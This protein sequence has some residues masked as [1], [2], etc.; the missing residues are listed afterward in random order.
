M[1]VLAP[2]VEW[3]AE[4]AL[5]KMPIVKNWTDDKTEGGCPLL[6]G[7]DKRLNKMLEDFDGYVRV[8][9]H[10]CECWLLA[11]KTQGNAI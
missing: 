3:V 1:G 9:L 5:S 4:G 2:V 10:R 11:R 6:H 8:S 7:I